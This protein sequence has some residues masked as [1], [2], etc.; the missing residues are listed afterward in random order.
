LVDGASGVD[1]RRVSFDR[2]AE[3]LM[4]L[5]EDLATE[6]SR[7]LREWLGDEVRVR[8]ARAS[9]ASAPAWVLVL[10]AERERKTAE[11]HGA[12]GEFETAF[13]AFARSDS[14]LSQAAR[15]DTMWVEPHVRL[16]RNDYRRSRMALARQDLHATTSWAER[17]LVDLRSALRLDP[18]DPRAL[19]IRGTIHYWTWL[20]NL[21]PDQEERQRLYDLAKA[22][23]ERAVEIDPTLAS[24]HA[25][26]GHL[27][28][29][30]NL[31]SSILA[32]RRAYEED[33][34]LDNADVVLWRL[35]TNSADLEQFTQARRWCEEGARRFPEDWR[36]TICRLDLMTMPAGE[37]AIDGAWALLARLD[38]LDAPP[39]Q[40]VYGEIV[41]GGVIGLAGQPDSANRVLLD[42]RSRGDPELDP[43][44]ELLSYEAAMRSL[45][46]DEDTAIELQLRYIAANPGHAFRPDE[47]IGWWWRPLRDHPR[48]HELVA[49]PDH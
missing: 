15:L 3:E 8:Q 37:P 17:A 49:V 20:L 48:F 33:A 23:L 32:A 4:A 10:R 24:A 47:P 31:A 30:E 13:D 28:S 27:Y 38:S 40:R 21:T 43:T 42:A 39:F 1:I 35:Y 45:M 44:Q 14:L 26:L 9:T 22:D 6:T 46:G 11:E 18:N 29:Q 5:Q 2:P 19:E 16:A 7:L 36:F 12:E 25:T 41:V 34:Y